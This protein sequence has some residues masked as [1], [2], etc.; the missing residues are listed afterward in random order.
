[1]LTRHVCHRQAPGVVAFIS[2][3][4]IP[5]EN[6][7]KGGASDAPLFAEE[8]VEFVGQ[9]IGVVVAESPRQAQTAAALVSVRYGHPKVRPRLRCHFLP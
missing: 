3:K 1:L 8:R 9:H 7:V 5:G 4:D 2:A 6:K